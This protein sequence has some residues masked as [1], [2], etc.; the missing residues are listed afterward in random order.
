MIL[1]A[2]VSVTLMFFGGWQVVDSIHTMYTAGYSVTEN[3][4]LLIGAVATLA[5]VLCF[6]LA[7]P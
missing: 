5:G 3:A 1:L 4:W 6:D 2:G 7:R